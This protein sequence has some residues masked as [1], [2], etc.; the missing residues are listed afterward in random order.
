[1]N[2]LYALLNLIRFKNLL[3]TALTQIFIKFYLINAY[4]S[5]SALSDVNFSIYLIALISIVASGYIINDIYDIETDK[6]NRPNSII[7]E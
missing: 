1:M 2:K 7:I 3:I 6:I 5:N 4:L